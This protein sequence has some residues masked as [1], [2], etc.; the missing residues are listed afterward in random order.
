MSRSNPTDNGVP[1]PSTRWFEWNGE[2]G[3]I[4]YYDKT[5]KENVDI[6]SNFRFMLLDQLGSVRGWHKASGSGIYSNEVRDTRQEPMIV[7]AFKGGTLAEGIYQAIRERITSK[8]VGAYFVTNLYIAFKGDGGQLQLGSL[9]MKGASLKAWM[10][11]VQAHRAELYAK[12]IRIHGFTE[13]QKGKVKFRIP[14]LEVT[15]VTKDTDA[16][17]VALDRELQKYLTG[18][19]KRTKVEQTQSTTV[20]PDAPP[21]DGPPADDYAGEFYEDEPAGGDPDQMDSDIPF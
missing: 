14:V 1:N 20:H 2:T 16:A 7:K 21:V 19:F 18:Y 9:R 10:E 11:F 5:A 13:G 15:D 3:T 6:G 8:A 17:A 12:A 4:R